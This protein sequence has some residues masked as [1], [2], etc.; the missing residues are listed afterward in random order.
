MLLWLTL[1]LCA[2]QGARSVHAQSAGPGQLRVAVEIAGC[3]DEVAHEVARLLQIELAPRVIEVATPEGLR[4]RI[5]C[6]QDTALLTIADPCGGDGSEQLNLAATPPDLR[7]R[8]IALQSAELVRALDLTRAQ[9]CPPASASSEPRETAQPA[10]ERARPFQLGAFAQ[11][12]TFS[13]D[14]R[15]LAGAG[16]RFSYDLSALTL[17]LDAAL[18]ARTFS[19]S[20]GEVELLWGYAAPQLAW[21]VRWRA[22]RFTLG[23]GYALG[24]ARIRGVA[25]R[26]GAGAGRVSGLW[27]APFAALELG[28]APTRFLVISAGASLGWVQA[29]VTGEVA[30]AK[31]VRLSGLWTQPRLAVT[32]AF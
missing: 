4:A 22:L 31:D 7:P 11:L 27:A 5:R 9:R 21:L 18:A 12:N 24:A 26:T 32:L 8:V 16:A 30:R 17:R 28:Y 19:P 20:L 13:R 25:T 3:G 29:G 1:L 14:G 15:W 2:G 23:A 10:P 6:E